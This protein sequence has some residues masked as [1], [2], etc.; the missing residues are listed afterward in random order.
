MSLNVGRIIDVEIFTQN[1]R[2]Y[3]TKSILHHHH[4]FFFW[5]VYP[6]Y[7]LTWLKLD[8]RKIKLLEQKSERVARVLDLEELDQDAEEEAKETHGDPDHEALLG[9]VL[10]LG[11][12][13]DEYNGG[14]A[15]KS[16]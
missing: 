13:T 11:N 7:L 12:N 15:D 8:P 3:N 14:S 1:F 16:V 5:Y 2:L 9:R 10:D 6:L 4:F